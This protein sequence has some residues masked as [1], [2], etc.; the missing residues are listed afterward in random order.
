MNLPDTKVSMPCLTEKDLTD[1]AY[2]LTQPVNWIALS[3]VREA[4]D[5]I[6]LKEIIENNNHYAKVIAKIEKPEAVAN[7][8]SIVKHT[9]AIMVAR[10]DLGV[11]ATWDTERYYQE[12][13]TESEAGYCSYA[14]DG[15]YD[16]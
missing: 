13:L 1:L 7:I 6:Q 10:G 8:K 14:D 11:E 4:S 16:Y 2:I 12:M 9:D 15:E 3:F 5:I